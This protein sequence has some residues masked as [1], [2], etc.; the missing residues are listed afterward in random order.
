M[1][2]FP[3]SSKKKLLPH[4]RE[5]SG[6]TRVALAVRRPDDSLVECDL[7]EAAGTFFPAEKFAALVKDPAVVGYAVETSAPYRRPSRFPGRA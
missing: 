4:L 7:P 1:R 6:G 5:N 2:T 3:R